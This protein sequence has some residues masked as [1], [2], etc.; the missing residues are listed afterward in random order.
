MEIEVGLSKGLDIMRDAKGPPARK[1][2][3]VRKCDLDKF[4]TRSPRIGIHRK[5]Q[6]DL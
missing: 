1:V 4:K 2:T 5:A 6:G 3:K